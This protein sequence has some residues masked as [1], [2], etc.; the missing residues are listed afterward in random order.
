LTYRRTETICLT[1]SVGAFRVECT[2][3]QSG[4]VGEEHAI[5]TQVILPRRGVFGVCRSGDRVL[6]DPNVAVILEANSSY[7]VDHPGTGGDCCTVLVFDDG[8]LAEALGDSRPGSAPV[9]VRTQLATR[10]LTRRSSADDLATEESAF[11]VL[12]LLADDFGAAAHKPSHVGDVQRKR[13]EQACAMIANQPEAPWRLATIAKAIYVSPF[14]LARQFRTTTGT[15]IWRYVL[16]LRLVAAL[17]RIAEGE[18]SLSRVASETGFSHHSH[19]TKHFRAMF[20][21]TPSDIRTK[22][23]RRSLENLKS[24][25]FSPGTA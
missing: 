1:P 21:T 14:H 4:G 15:T 18:T 24:S 25:T 5:T 7:S 2:A 16:R 10:A 6:A 19:L 17:D 11:A 3:P 12:M 8:V 23:T 20:G 13:V 22:L 9:S